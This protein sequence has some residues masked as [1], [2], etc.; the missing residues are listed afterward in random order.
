MSAEPGVS[1][2]NA[3]AERLERI[4]A[5]LDDPATADAAAVALAKEAAQI[6]AEAGATAADAARAAAESGGET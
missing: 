3:A 2:L 5:E 1:Q 6:A 4:A